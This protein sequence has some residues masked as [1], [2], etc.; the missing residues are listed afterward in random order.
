MPKLQVLPS[1][2]WDVTMSKSREN[3]SWNKAFQFP[4][5]RKATIL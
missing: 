2:N 4:D 1:E 3:S 5:P